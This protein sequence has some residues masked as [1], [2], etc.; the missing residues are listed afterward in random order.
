MQ[1]SEN[2]PK[3]PNSKQK[4]EEPLPSNVHMERTVLGALLVENKV[5]DDGIST[6]TVDDFLL[7]SHQRIFKQ[8]GGMLRSKRGVDIQ[9]LDD[10]L[11]RS[12]ELFTVGGPAYIC[13]LTE[14]IPCMREGKFYFHQY[15]DQLKE[16]GKLRR[17]IGACHDAIEAAKK[18]E[19]KSEEI[20]K[21][22]GIQLR[23]I[24]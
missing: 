8:I 7:D 14:G 12:G 19:T 3:R 15:I 13:Y 6:L 16:Y 17:I 23:G 4:P 20:V 21:A 2:S 11:Q 9:L 1:N 10:A 18:M 5:W 24:R 22:M